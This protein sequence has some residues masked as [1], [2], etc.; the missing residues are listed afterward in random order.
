MRSESLDSAE[1]LARW[2][3]CATE[4]KNDE[5]VVVLIAFIA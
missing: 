2:G 4:E 3:C 5:F 1:A